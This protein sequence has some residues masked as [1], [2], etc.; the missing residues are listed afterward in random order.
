MAD[1]GDVE[2]MV[3]NWERDAA[4]RARRYEQLREQ[5]EQIS[6]TESVAQGA[7]SVTV[8]ANGVPT[9]VSM[10]DGVRKM[11][12]DEIAAN[13]VRAM[14]KAQAKYPQRLQE[15]TAATVGE[16]ATTRHLLATAAERFPESPAEEDEPSRPAPGGQLRVEIEEEE[17]E[18]PRRPRG[19]VPRRRPARASED[20]NGGFDDFDDF[21]GQSFLRRD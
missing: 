14:R 6:I 11:S 21:G 9:D 16:D 12:P 1:L 8:G 10:T 2:R 5:V 13:V 7:V 15:I 4:E 18:T 17:P 19:Q 20:E 3:D